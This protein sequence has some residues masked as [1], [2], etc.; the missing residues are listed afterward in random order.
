MSFI[1]NNND[2]GCHAT[3]AAE[4]VTWTGTVTDRGATQARESLVT[5]TPLTRE[6]VEAWGIKLILV[7]SGSIAISITTPSHIANSDTDN[8]RIGSAD[9]SASQGPSG[10]AVVG[11]VVGSIAGVVLLAVGAS[12]LYCRKKSGPTTSTSS[13]MLQKRAPN[14]RTSS[15]Q[16][17]MANQARWEH[18]HQAR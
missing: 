17:Q 14:P 13:L 4:G 3:A 8:H 18:M 9:A 5:L 7:T 2:Y 6:S 1:Y 12:L 16:P 15:Y 11:I 10:R